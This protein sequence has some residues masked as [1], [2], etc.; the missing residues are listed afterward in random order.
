MDSPTGAGEVTIRI[1]TP[2]GTGTAMLTERSAVV[3]P[4]NCLLSPVS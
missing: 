2:G 1:W 3:T 4:C